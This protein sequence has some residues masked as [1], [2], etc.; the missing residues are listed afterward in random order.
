MSAPCYV[1]KEDNARVRKLTNNSGAALVDGEF[2]LLGK[3]PVC[4]NGA[5][6]SGSVGDF[7]CGGIR[8]QAND[9]VTSEDTFG[10][11]NAP[12]YWNG[13]DKKFS[14]TRTK[15]YYEVGQVA[16]VKTSGIVMIDLY[17]VALIVPHM[18]DLVD[19]TITNLT[20][21]QILKASSGIFVNAADAT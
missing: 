7:V 5:V 9:F 3:F 21:N 18:D 1:E 14:D 17:D 13:T 2:A 12:A 11:A 10:T 19:V 6:S 20:D 8:I 4:A 15:G 16:V